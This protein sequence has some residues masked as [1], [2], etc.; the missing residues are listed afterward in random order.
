MTNPDPVVPP[1]HHTHTV[2]ALN[3]S[4]AFSEI[5]NR[6]LKLLES[7]RTDP[8]GVSAED[9]AT[10]LV[11]AVD[12]LQFVSNFALSSL[13]S[14]AATLVPPDAIEQALSDSAEARLGRSDEEQNQRNFELVE[15]Y[16]HEM[17]VVVPDHHGPMP[18][19]S[20]G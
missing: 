7:L 9:V 15:P 19:G 5:N 11:A 20:P 12:T 3:P 1:G 10:A 4:E 8:T 17:V 14:A 16:M 13:M 2:M 18:G 6:V